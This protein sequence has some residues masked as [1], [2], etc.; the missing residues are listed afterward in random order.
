[1]R[2]VRSI[3]ALAHALGIEV[4]AERVSELEQLER[5]RAAGCD[6][7]QGNLL[8]PPAPGAE[9]RFGPTALW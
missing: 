8:G 9:A 1:M 3:V 2:V 6:M 4:V 5:L 7:V